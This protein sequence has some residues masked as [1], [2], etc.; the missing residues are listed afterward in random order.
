MCAASNWAL[1]YPQLPV[2][3]VSLR[4]VTVES[5]YQAVPPM[6]NCRFSRSV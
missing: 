4:M 3:T 6:T 1:I 5:R 2:V